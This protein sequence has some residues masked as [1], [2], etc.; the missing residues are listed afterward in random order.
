VL[1]DG[2]PLDE[3]YAGPS[4]Y[5]GQF[6]VPDGAYLL[7]GD[8]RDASHDSRIWAD[9]YVPRRHLKGRLYPVAP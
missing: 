3:P 6:R 7:L 4:I 2:Q 9:P 1:V 5:H 8:N